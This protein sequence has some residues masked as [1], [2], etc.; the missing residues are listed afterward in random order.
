MMKKL[1]GL[2]TNKY[3][4]ATAIFSVWML[5]LDQN[6]W[7][8]MRQRRNELQ[9][10][11]GNIDYLNHEIERMESEKKGLASDPKMLEQYAR[12]HYHMKRDNEDIY[13]INR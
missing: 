5:Y 2:L 4:I 10:V 8:T 1:F 7:F 9:Q 3:L 11:R 13:I 12:E 6:D